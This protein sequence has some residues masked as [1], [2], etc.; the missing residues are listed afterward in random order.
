MQVPPSGGCR[1][2]MRLCVLQGV[3]ARLQTKESQSFIFIA[4][5]N[6]SFQPG[7]LNVERQPHAHSQ[8]AETK[9]QNKMR[10]LNN[11]VNFI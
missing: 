7:C 4:Y 5:P 8:N 11:I 2:E 1:I 3:A 10:D 6:K 9:L